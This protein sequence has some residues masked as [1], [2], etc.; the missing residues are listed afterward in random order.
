[1]VRRSITSIRS[2]DPQSK[3]MILTGM[4]QQL[5]PTH[6]VYFMCLQSYQCT[7]M[8]QSWKCGLSYQIMVVMQ[9]LSCVLL[10]VT[11]GLQPTRLFCPWGFFRQEYWNKQPFPSPMYLPH[12]GIEPRSLALQAD[13]LLTEPPEKLTY[14]E[15]NLYQ[16]QM[17]GS[18]FS[19]HQ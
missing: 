9:S 8:N 18:F 19:L 12:P 7:S 17:F 1:M 2:K 16:R 6:T 4:R 11:H 10:F 14:Q 3:Q 5:K 15:K 13:S